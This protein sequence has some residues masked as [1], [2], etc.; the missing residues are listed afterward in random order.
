MDQLTFVVDEDVDYAIARYLQSLD[1][2]VEYVPFV[3]GKGT[4]DAAI[5]AYAKGLY[6]IIVTHNHRH[7]QA[8]AE[9]ALG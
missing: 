8:F 5:L 2:Q 3:L 4:Q 9:R 1:H 7:F 6:A